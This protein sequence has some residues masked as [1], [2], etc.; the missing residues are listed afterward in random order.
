M[1][2]KQV[3]HDESSSF[4]SNLGQRLVLTL[5]RFFCVEFR[6]CPASWLCSDQDKLQQP[7]IHQHR[8][9]V[10]ITSSYTPN[11][12]READSTWLGG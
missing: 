4:I 1:S 11:T 5:I 8:L 2:M 3:R 12:A 9:V 7:K 10:F 6:I